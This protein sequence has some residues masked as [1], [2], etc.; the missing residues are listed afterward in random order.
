MASATET[1][2]WGR[3]RGRSGRASSSDEAR[4][5]QPISRFSVWVNCAVRAPWDSGMRFS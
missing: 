3:A 2:V 1:V 5:S 4:E